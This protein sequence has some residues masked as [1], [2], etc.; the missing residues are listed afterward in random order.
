MVPRTMK[1][2]EKVGKKIT[3]HKASVVGTGSFLEM[4]LFSQTLPKRNTIDMFCLNL[5]SLLLG[6]DQTGSLP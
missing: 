6:N 5:G 2:E 4:T 1:G 3:S